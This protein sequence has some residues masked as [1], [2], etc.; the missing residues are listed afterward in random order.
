MGPVS[1]IGS[2][3]QPQLYLD[4]SGLDAG[5]YHLSWVGCGNTELTARPSSNDH[6][7]D[8]RPLRRRIYLRTRKAVNDGRGARP[9]FLFPA[10][11]PT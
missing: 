3:W 11:G 7:A 9:S 2:S 1:V 6:V 8:H 5:S 10:C 4:I